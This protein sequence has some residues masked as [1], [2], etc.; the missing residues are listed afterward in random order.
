MADATLLERLIAG[1]PEAAEQAR[2]MLGEVTQAFGALAEQMATHL[3]PALES[4]LAAA[5]AL[6]EAAWEQYRAAGAPYGDNN[7]G[8]LRWFTEEYHFRSAVE[9]YREEVAWRKT[10][11]E[12]RERFTQT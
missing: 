6:D 12:I 1:D 3:L 9:K 2:E 8:R 7:E 4:V 10:L 11:I 5:K